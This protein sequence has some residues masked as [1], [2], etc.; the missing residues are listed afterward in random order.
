MT[1]APSPTPRPPAPSKAPGQASPPP[2]SV[3]FVETQTMLLPG[4]ITLESGR[5][6]RDVVVAYE[7]YGSINAARDN[8]ILVCHA[9]S[10]D[11]HA[12]GYHEGGGA[13]PGW[14]D[15]MIG[16]GKAFDTERYAVLC[17]NV[18]GGCR[19]TTGP[20]S[21]DP[22]THEPYAATFPIVTIDDMVMVQAALLDRLAIRTLAAVAGGSMGGMQALHWSVSRPERVESVVVLASCARL[23]AQALAFNAVGRQAIMSDP[24]W[25]GGRYPADDPPAGGL[26]AARM[27][28]H[29]TYLSAEGLEHRFGRR[30]QYGDGDGFTLD[31]DFQVESYLEHQGTSFVNRFDANCYLY[32]TRALDYFDLGATFSSLNAALGRATASFFLASM[33][34][35]WLYP[36][37]QTEELASALA[38]AGNPAEVVAVESLHGHDGFLLEHEA[39]SPRISAF[40]QRRRVTR[41]PTTR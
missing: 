10:G 16:P 36:P 40:L 32:M 11:A 31:T 37:V 7:L 2:G 18:L 28:G 25:R 24:R 17:S 8:V 22:D 23:T 20:L 6:L 14:W 5:T 35:D 19:G 13:K 27:I 33:S 39:L 3:G 15:T 4:P 26:A 34:T 29:L 12:A 41:L 30:H 38:A 21:L 9:L 1:L